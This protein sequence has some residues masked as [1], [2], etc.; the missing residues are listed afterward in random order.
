MNPDISRVERSHREAQR[1]YDRISRWY[2]LLEGYWERK[3]RVAALQLLSASQG[4]RVLEI[5][6]GPGHSLVA[7]AAAVGISGRV[8][9]LDLSPG[10]LRVTQSRIEL[11]QLPLRPGLCRGDALRIPL[12]DG[13]FDALLMSFVLELFDTPEIPQVLAECQRVLRGGGRVGVVALS[14]AGPHSRLRDVYEWG[15]ALFPWLLDCRPIFVRRSLEDAGF[16]TCHATDASL[17]GL[18]VEAVA[19][20]KPG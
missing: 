5:G 4:E 3:A 20:E 14:K 15:H 16:H 6:P 8:C 9:G 17:W 7:L 13:T 11:A 1:T 18:P 10:M 19:A 12:A 2:D